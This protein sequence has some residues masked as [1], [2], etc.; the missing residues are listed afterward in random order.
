MPYF[1]FDIGIPVKRCYTDESGE[2]SGK[3][4]S[5]LIQ[6]I[7]MIDGLERIRLGSLETGI[8]SEDLVRGL[9]DIPKFCPQFH[10]SLQS[11]CDSVLK[12][13]NRHYL[14]ADFTGSVNMIRKYFPD[15]AITT[16][17][18]AG[19]PGESDEEFE[20]TVKFVK[21]TGFS[22]LHVFPFSRRKGTR[23]DKMPSQI[24]R[25]VKNERTRILIQTG[26]EVRQKYES[27]F[28]GR[29]CP[30]LIEEITPPRHLEGYTPEYIRVKIQL[31]P[32]PDQCSQH[33]IGK[34]ITAIPYTFS[35]G[36]L[37]ARE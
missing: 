5:G 19:F 12:R 8:V 30:V 37:L 28:I 25:A 6:Q 24:T 11:G 33:Y 27:K 16:D 21:E 9:K 4:L 35:N 18:I 23:A 22:R 17:I 1:L 14:T 29:P 7:S 36:I 3:S 32:T 20:Q 10:L 13:M 31:P 15:A 2:E 26:E 34:T